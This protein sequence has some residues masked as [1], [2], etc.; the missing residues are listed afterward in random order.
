MPNELSIQLG[1]EL[2]ESS[3]STVKQQIEDLKDP[4]K[5]KVQIS[6]DTK[7]VEAQI[8][9]LKNSLSG[10]SAAKIVLDVNKSA[11]NANINNYKNVIAQKFTQLPIKAVID[12]NKSQSNANIK[13]YINQ[14]KQQLQ[15]L[16][17]TIQPV[18]GGNGTKGN[19]STGTISSSPRIASNVSP[20]VANIDKYSKSLEEAAQKYASAFSDQNAKLSFIQI[21]TNVEG[22]D[23]AIV[24]FKNDIGQTTDVMFKF[25][26]VLDQSGELIGGK[27]VTTG[28]QLKQTFS[29]SSKEIESTLNKLS[30]FQKSLNTIQSKGF[31][32]TNQLSG[33]YA[34]P[35]EKEMQRIQ[36]EIDKFKQNASNNKV[37][38]SSDEIRKLGE[39]IDALDKLRIK[40]QNVQWQARQMSATDITSQVKILRNNVT[41]LENSLKND[42]VFS[43]FQQ[44]IDNLKTSLKTV[45]QDGGISVG[46]W[47][48]QWR[49]LNSEINKYK[50][51]VTG[52]A[53]MQAY[54]IRN[55]QLKDITKIRNVLNSKAGTA[56]IDEQRQKLDQLAASYNNLIKQM[57][58]G[59]LS[60]DRFAN[61]QSELSILD[62]QLTGFKTAAKNIQD[63]E[64][65]G[66]KEAGISKLK[67][68]FEELQNSVSKFQL[69]K[70]IQDSFT[71][72]GNAL[73]GGNTDAL[74]LQQ[75]INEFG[76]LKAKIDEFKNSLQGMSQTFVQDISSGGLKQV[77]DLLSG[78]LG[79]TTTDGATAIRQQ[80][81]GLAQE[82]Q[83]LMH[84]LSDP[85]ITKAQFDSIAQQVAALNKEL[86]S[87]TTSANRY[88]NFVNDPSKMEQFGNQ[89]ENL[90]VRF[91]DLKKTYTGAFS[92]SPD[93]QAQAQQIEQALQNVDNISLSNVRSSIQLFSNNLKQA[94]GESLSL[95][96]ALSQNLGGVGQ[97]LARFVSS[98]YIISK[99]ISG[100]KSLVNE[101]GGLDSALVDLQKVTGLTGTALE[102]F[103]DQAFE[104]GKTLGRTGQDVIEATATF[105][106][107]GYDL[108]E[109]T[110]LAQSAL[111]MTNVG[112]DINSTADAASDMISILKAFDKQA[113]ESMR[114]ID[115]LY[116]VSNKEPLDFGNLTQML[117]TA[118]GT[119]AQ[120]G[121]S[122]EETMGLVTGAFATMRDTSVANGLIMISQRLR[123][124]KEDGTDIEE[125]FI[126]KLKKQLGDVGVAI[127][128]QNGELRSTYDILNDLAAVWDTLGSKQR[129]Y[130]GEKVAGNRQV[131]TL[132]AIMQNW[133]VVKDTIEDANSALGAATEGNKMYMESIQGRITQFKSAMQ[134]LATTTIES[135]FIKNLTSAGTQIV[136]LITQI[137]GLVPVLTTILGIVLTFKGA[138]I[139]EGLGNI[140][141]ALGGIVS[142]KAGLLGFIGILMTAM[143]VLTTFSSAAN[144]YKKSLSNLKN[145]QQAYTDGQEKVK[146]LNSELETTQSKIDD[147]LK[148]DKLTFVEENELNDLRNVNE[149][150][151]EQLKVEEALQ[152][153]RKN[154]A[155]SA[156]NTA[157]ASFK[158]EE[159]GIVQVG[160]TLSDIWGDVTG[161]FVNKSIVDPYN[162][163][164]L[165]PVG[166]Y[167]TSSPL[168]NFGSDLKAYQ[169]LM[170]EAGDVRKELLE[171]PSEE[172][173]TLASTLTNMASQYFE[174]AKSAYEQLFE[175]SNGVIR[176][177][178]TE[179][180]F[181]LL[182]AM[183][184]ALIDYKK[185]AEDLSAGGIKTDLFNEI[186]KSETYKETTKALSELVKEGKLTEETFGNTVGIDNFTKALDSIG[187]STKDA[188]DYLKSINKETEEATTKETNAMRLDTIAEALF[189][190]QPQY[191]TLSKAITE[192]NKAGALSF[193]TYDMLL[194]QLPQMAEFL[195]LTA[196]GYVLN[197][198]AVYAYIEAEQNEQKL[199]ALQYILEQ[200]EALRK[201]EDAQKDVNTA[202]SEE[203]YNDK[204]SALQ[205][206]VDRATALVR[207][208]NSATDAF[209]RFKAAQ[210]TP[211]GDENY[212]EMGKML[213]VVKEGRKT[214]K[215]GTDDFQE[216][217]SG[218]LGRDW[219]SRVGVKGGYKTT[220][221]AYKEAERL[222]KR[223]FGQKQEKTGM[224]NFVKDAQK[225][226]VMQYDKET[227]FLS[228]VEGFD[229]YESIAEKMN[230]S[231][232]AVQSMVELM[233]TYADV[234]EKKFEFPEIVSEEDKK[235]IE[236]KKLQDKQEGLESEKKTLQA[237]MDK[238]EGGPTTEQIKKMNELD[239]GIEE[240]RV[241]LEALAESGEKTEES[242][243]LEDAKTK[244]DELA[245]T[246]ATLGGEPVVIDV[247]ITG[248]FFELLEKFP[249]LKSYVEENYPSIN[250]EVAG[251]AEEKTKE[252]I[253][254]LDKVE[255]G[256]NANVE[257]T[258]NASEV[259][260][261]PREVLHEMDNT[262]FDTTL[263][264]T[265][266][267]SDKIEKPAE[268]LY[269]MDGSVFETTLD[270]KESVSDGIQNANDELI[271]FEETEHHADIEARNATEAGIAL[272]KDAVDSY[273]STEAEKNIIIKPIIEPLSEEEKEYWDS[274]FDNDKKVNVK[275]GET[276][277]DNWDDIWD[278]YKDNWDDIWGNNGNNYDSYKDNWDDIWG[279]EE[280]VEL[281][282]EIKPP[283]DTGEIFIQD[284]QDQVDHDSTK[285]E[286][287]ANP[288]NETTEPTQTPNTSPLSSGD[289]FNIGTTLAEGL[290]EEISD[291]TS[292]FTHAYL[293]LNNA[294]DEYK[295]VDQSDATKVEEATNKL[296]TEAQK[297][298]EVW[299]ALTDL[300]DYNL[301]I[302]EETRASIDKIISLA[303]ST[304]T[305]TVT[306]DLS[307][308]QDPEVDPITAKVNADTAPAKREINKLNGEEI[309]LKVRTQEV[310]G[311]ATGTRN[312]T[313]GLSLVDEKGAELIE[314]TSRGTFELGTDKGAR[315]TNLDKG[316]VVHTAKETKTILSR[317]A[318]IGGF[319]RDGLNK[320]KSIIGNAF[321]TGATGSINWKRIMGTLTS[322]RDKASGKSSN[323]SNAKG[324]SYKKLK[325]WFEK[326]F[327]WA[328]IR[329]QRLQTITN[330][331]ILSASEAIGYAAKNNELNSAIKSVGDQIEAT[332]AAYDL[333]IK[334]ADV[335][336]KK[337]KLSQD[338]VNKIQQGTIEISS[339]KKETQEK[340]KMYQEWYNKAMDCV[341]AL[342]DLREQ[343]KELAKQ[344]LD[345]IITHYNNRITRLDNIV[346]QREAEL[347]LATAQG[348]ELQSSDYN[349]SI[350]ATTQKLENLVAQ[351]D[352][353]Q[354]EMSA[355]ISQGL[356]E[357][358]SD[359]WYDYNSKLQDL[360]KT[361]TD[362][363][364]AIIELHDTVNE[365]TLT[366]LGYDLDAITN[367][368]SRMQDAM[369]LHQAQGLDEVADAYKELIENGMAQ[370]ANLE[371]QNRQYREQQKGL[372]VMSEKYQELE[373]NI[374][375]NISTI[376]S[377]KVSQEEW[378]DAVL[379][380]E[381]NKLNKYKDALEK[382][383]DQYQRQ[384]ELQQAIVDLEKARTQRTQRVY[385]EGVGFTYIADQDELKKAQENLE[386]VVHNQLI[387]KIDDLIDAL[388][389]TK[390][391]TN[392]YDAN[393]N[394]LGTAYTLPII[395]DYATLLSNSTTNS[396]A[397]SDVM[398][399]IKTGF[400]DQI[401]TSTGSIGN[402][403]NISIGD[404]V[405][406]GVETPDALAEALVANFSNALVKALYDKRLT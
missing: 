261:R 75:R 305:V 186:W 318:K 129:Q 353:L 403:Y 367:S 152:D 99:V 336:A 323:S 380:L 100:I 331:W 49:E 5:N 247:Q 285:V 187:V 23:T 54:D 329:L 363:K 272:A 350:D 196:N 366:K 38:M 127:E 87:T 67:N 165:N 265:D 1:V 288:T 280:E 345:N 27:W 269:E 281:P 393:G 215:Y 402:D 371:E 226:G 277:K 309:V 250:L 89:V 241:G 19:G 315:F 42:G 273:T 98:T 169:R 117:V 153:V 218:I 211:N 119:L 383:N 368:A 232:E 297:F 44:N 95:S 212:G 233:N 17:V 40:Q 276:N 145:S 65:T 162:G 47:Q 375:S 262:V 282:V 319:F 346:S 337:A 392:V 171:S 243:T 237:E 167:K 192:Q 18:V 90:R 143:T 252:V 351:R 179:E 29:D 330:S 151:K 271:S 398:E 120:T 125:N 110:A 79:F 170:K 199:D 207:Q 389:D 185:E 204:K 370:I 361:I 101:V 307:Q 306:S 397:I 356:I 52:Q 386:D 77:Q 396:K 257:A 388:E 395:D 174:S 7:Q 258:D 374:Q 216:A 378:N 146:S 373:S 161:K 311:N 2:E 177:S 358:E 357:E 195:T 91:E 86:S 22:A 235:A 66:K 80:L 111:V 62:K 230:I 173:K 316:D 73:S 251:N 154:N 12:I 36:S 148:K 6:V 39:D 399:A 71:N 88:L 340:I 394:L 359:D 302:P 320:G 149:Q 301:I 68:D 26:E 213:S 106:R 379:D 244:I 74:N 76:Q 286:V 37:A 16:A 317:M 81:E 41:E 63:I 314:H 290:P 292:E 59:K 242:L 113:N 94:S 259:I 313:G 404:I 193:A 135:S 327:D 20:G 293:D 369:N 121:T 385:R 31:D 4:K 264:A 217:V 141:K 150:L 14:I 168:A 349:T 270:A 255:K 228:F 248:P 139:A 253:D 82:Y 382:T 208:I 365:L 400:I 97:Y 326:L 21:K 181:V 334:E 134:E 231:P 183:G 263:D 223:Y 236:K 284:I 102:K 32:R 46:K 34:T 298:V 136:K 299:S 107:A 85:N 342:T 131:K 61:L 13:S 205:A 35:V 128:D 70:D 335:V 130:L 202:L 3:F 24:Q 387:G 294:F 222:G 190:N 11:S 28:E 57:E 229:T 214:G 15:N 194:Q 176:N 123:G 362:T 390:N 191:E 364:T 158:S 180:S 266:E 8:N 401:M 295:T 289:F 55:D 260:E 296:Q 50:S 116:N 175:A 245:T 239:L 291:K 137:G 155:G 360:E 159:T 112:V 312:A 103:T 203:E 344:K 33:Q 220:E 109:S 142:G 381:I 219:Q 268:V 310:E 178:F 84:Q 108:Q 406:E 72:L 200:E 166:G 339:Y 206:E 60:R 10:K 338:I 267:A 224:N 283:E 78:K 354:R 287:P 254:N 30:S 45:G 347:A 92:K 56:G 132:N 122:L 300:D 114:V 69:P 275:A 274:L 372:D 51:S 172:K 9:G 188:I 304:E 104:I 48:S 156:F 182:D 140:A 333:Y 321:A 227:G 144:K 201:L 160:N 391:D 118:G 355:L 147:L 341:D 93:L 278:D 157:V 303:G 209:A 83:N 240:C 189:T 348:I 64:W 377:M 163:E 384:K 105:S 133:N 352:A 25:E 246:I 138:K 332:T 234:G 221:A 225:A 43:K 325:K 198:E 324:T 279:N 58:S 256:A 343:E 115:E 184:K 238:T 308:W 197:T 210:S 249:E 376:N 322:A 96:Q 126:P 328:E 405:L 124:V 164:L 53:A